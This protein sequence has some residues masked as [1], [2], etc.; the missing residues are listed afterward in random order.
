MIVGFGSVHIEVLAAPLRLPGESIVALGEHA[1]DVRMD[2]GGTGGNIAINCAALGVPVRFCTALNPGAHSR[3]IVE[4]MEGS[5]IELV[6]HQAQLPA[7]VQVVELD[8]EGSQV[9]SIASL[10]IEAANLD[11][12]WIAS[13][14]DGALMVYADCYLCAATLVR[15]ASAAEAARIPFFIASVSPDRT[16]RAAMAIQNGAL[17]AGLFM[18]RRDANFLKQTMDQ[19]EDD[20]SPAPEWLRNTQPRKPMSDSDLSGFLG[21][22]L[23]ISDI[24]SGAVLIDEH[25]ERGIPGGNSREAVRSL[26][27]AAEALMAGVMCSA[28]TGSKSVAKSL[29]SAV[30]TAA[31]VAAR[32]NSNLSQPLALD[33]AIDA[34]REGAQKDGLTRLLN[35]SSAAAIGER[36]IERAILRNKPLAVIV[37]DIDHFK[38]VN[39]TW[40]HAKG[41]EVIAGV[42]R[43]ASEAMRETD[44]CARWG[45]EEFVCILPGASLDVAH[46]IAERIRQQVQSTIKEPREITVSLGVALLQ[47]GERLPSLVARADAAL[48][49]AKRSGRNCTSVAPQSFEQAEREAV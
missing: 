22:R 44:I 2:I 18:T 15:I 33:R 35:R 7:A 41:D 30:R 13:A 38:S 46:R 45:G 27:G 3:I 37:L 11:D 1:G 31:A 34:Y 4:H 49:F 8:D 29:D 25:G 32:D 28:L 6:V 17:C 26:M 12:D 40:G 5:G 24:S 21:C 10:P 14:L 23:I 43:V 19:A 16:L 42:A 36:H 20:A 47:P 48:Y 39:D 9:R